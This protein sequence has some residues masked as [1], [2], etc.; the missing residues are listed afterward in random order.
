MSDYK[1]KFFDKSHNARLKN[2]AKDRQI[3]LARLQLL[4][5]AIKRYMSISRL[6]AAT[7][8]GCGNSTAGTYL[9]LLLKAGVVRVGSMHGTRIASYE[10]TNDQAAE[11]KLFADLRASV[12]DAERGMFLDRADVIQ[13]DEETVDRKFAQKV[14]R[15]KATQIGVARDALVAALFGNGPAHA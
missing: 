15:A 7:V 14:V 5:P 2:M 6:E 3:R 9:G 8:M 10:P 12:E 4:V 1:D 11:D 13:E